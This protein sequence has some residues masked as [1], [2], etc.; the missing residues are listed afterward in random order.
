MPVRHLR[1]FC[2]FGYR[3]VFKNPFEENDPAVSE[4]RFFP[5]VD[6]DM[7]TETRLSGIPFAGMVGVFSVHMRNIHKG[8][9]KTQDVKK[10]W[11]EKENLFP[12]SFTNE[13]ASFIIS[14]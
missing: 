6:P 14:A 1:G 2:R 8:I 12:R 10:D 3:A 7:A 11:Q 13:C 4:K 9:T 5:T